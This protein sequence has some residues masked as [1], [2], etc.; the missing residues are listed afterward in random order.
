MSDTKQPINNPDEFET[1]VFR[2][3]EEKFEDPLIADD[4]PEIVRKKPVDRIDDSISVDDKLDAG[5]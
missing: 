2:K 4:K 5:K 1:P 3:P